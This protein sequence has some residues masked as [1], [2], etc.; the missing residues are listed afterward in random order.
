MIKNLTED[1]LWNLVDK[2]RGLAAAARDTSMPWINADPLIATAQVFNSAAE[3][4]S[5][6]ILDSE[7]Q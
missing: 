2:W 6:L 5:D 7:D 4:L 1:D 3:D